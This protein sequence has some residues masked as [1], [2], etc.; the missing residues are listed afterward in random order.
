MKSRRDFWSKKVFPAYFCEVD[1]RSKLPLFPSMYALSV[2]F[3]STFRPFC[4]LSVGTASS[5][6]AVKSKFSSS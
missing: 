2:H 4:P 3:P 5:M 6:K 1:L